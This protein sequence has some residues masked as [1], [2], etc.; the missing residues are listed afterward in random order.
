MFLA[1]AVRQRAMHEPQRNTHVLEQI[2][3]LHMLLSVGLQIIQQKAYLAKAAS[4]HWRHRK[5]K[6]Q[7]KLLSRG[8]V[9]LEQSGPHELP[10]EQAPC[11]MHSRLL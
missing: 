6:A 11:K 7:C 9:A 10:R 1:S 4:T 3:K 2:S 8:F 5:S